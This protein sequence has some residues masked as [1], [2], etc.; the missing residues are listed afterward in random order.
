MTRAHQGLLAAQ[1]LKKVLVIAGSQNNL[2]AAYRNLPT[3]D[4]GENLKKA[5]VCY[6]AALR[7]HTERD[8]P[9]EWAMTQNNLGIVYQNLPTGDRSENLKKAIACY[10]TAIRGYESTGLTKEAERVKRLL[11]SLQEELSS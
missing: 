7:V 8:F 2:G 10:E 3:G 11:V 4:R 6:E 1:A 9:V 5:I